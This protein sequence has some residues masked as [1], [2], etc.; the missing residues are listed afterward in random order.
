MEVKKTCLLKL[1]LIIIERTQN[2]L[3][4]FMIFQ[5]L[6]VY[7]KKKLHSKNVGIYT[8]DSKFAY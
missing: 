8:I 5:I 7:T 4:L 1:S 3:A 2:I 6:I